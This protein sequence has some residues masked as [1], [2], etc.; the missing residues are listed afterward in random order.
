MEAASSER[1]DFL[2]SIKPGYA[3]LIVEGEKTVE[4]RRRFTKNVA[5]GSIV[6][7]YCTSPTQ[8]IIGFARIKKVELLPLDT[9]W[10]KHG[11]RAK[12]DEEDFDSYFLGCDE[13]YAILFDKAVRLKSR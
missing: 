13:G 1:R 7:I 3:E 6:L 5:A 4:L 9:L 8:A 2:F 12:I 11:S 10:S